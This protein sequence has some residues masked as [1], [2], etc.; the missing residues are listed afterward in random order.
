LKQDARFSQLQRT[1]KGGKDSCCYRVTVGAGKKL[2]KKR[3]KKG[4]ADR[5][6]PESA[7]DEWRRGRTASGILCHKG[8]KGSPY[9]QIPLVVD[10]AVV[11]RLARAGGQ[12]TSSR[13]RKAPYSRKYREV[14]VSQIVSPESTENVKRCV[15]TRLPETKVL[16]P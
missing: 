7:A 9:V 12:L 11:K 8:R 14:R 6:C 5:A 2:F 4:P 10:P 16:T 13:K 3:K 1:S 15:R